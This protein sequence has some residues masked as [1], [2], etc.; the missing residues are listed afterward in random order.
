[1]LAADSVL[2][3][4]WHVV[5]SSEDVQENQILSIKLLGEDLIVWRSG[6]PLRYPRQRRSPVMVWRDQCPH[7]GA[8]LS[9]GSIEGDRLI[10][11][12]HG[13]A[14]N[15][16]GQCV[17][18]PAHPDHKPSPR[19]RVQS[20]ST[21]ER[22][23]LIWV[24]LSSTADQSQ[25]PI[26][27]EWDDPSY[28]K[29]LCGA[30]TYES[31]G[32]RAIENFLDVSH[33]PFVHDR[34]LGDRDRTAVADYTVKVKPDAIAL[35]NVR[36]WQPDPDGTG[37]GREVIYNYLVSR[38]LTASFVKIADTN[39]LAIF[40]TVSP[41]SEEC[42]RGWMWIAMNYG[43]EIPETDLKTFQD[44]VVRQD[45]PIVESQRPKRLP[46]DLQSEFHLPCDRA[47]IAYR[48]WLKQLGVS[49][50]TF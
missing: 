2:L 49:F 8:A 45:I 29:F 34:L 27:P 16:S 3:N 10:C 17:Y 15:P 33:F 28:R 19:D 1:M 20:F 39:R 43:H 4:D 40:F 44:Q 21:Q 25:I 18:V 36:L 37:I 46:L 30:Y 6:S 14:Y 13:L 38:P 12:Y 5:A 35:E 7:R 9:L 31:S 47:S 50:G 22:Y 41:V 42:C 23:G 32:F 48:K 26:F 24:C 11:P